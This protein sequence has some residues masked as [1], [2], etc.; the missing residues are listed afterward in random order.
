MNF[1]V[2]PNV[3]ELGLPRR[4]PRIRREKFYPDASVRFP[5]R[6]YPAAASKI[7]P[8]NPSMTRVVARPIADEPVPS[9]PSENIIWEKV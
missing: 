4:T 1:M 5:P 8:V 3:T 7:K 6:R 9:N 2:S